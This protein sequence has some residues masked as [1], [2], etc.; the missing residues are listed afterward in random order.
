MDHLFADDST[1]IADV[2]VRDTTVAGA[3]TQQVETFCQQVHYAQHAGADSWRYGLWHGLD[4]L[5][6]VTYNMPTTDAADGV[7]GP[8]RRQR[9]RHM[10]RLALA[11]DAPPNSESRLIVH[12]LRLLRADNPDALAVLTFSDPDQ[13]N[14]F[15][16]VAQVGLV[17]QATNALYTGEG[18]QPRYYWDPVNK[19]RMATSHLSSRQAREKGWEVHTGSPKH[20]YVYLLGTPAE[21]RRLRAELLLPVI[22]D[23][24]H[25]ER[26][27]KPDYDDAARWLREK[28]AQ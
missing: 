26:Y 25:P 10:G 11:H 16:G 9:I 21:R 3:T 13:R 6:I 1:P 19:R 5:G 22:A 7:F 24:Q 12:S 17:Y 20:R 23:Q 14:P 18:G 28:L 8:D 27:P 15:T 2:K 4:L